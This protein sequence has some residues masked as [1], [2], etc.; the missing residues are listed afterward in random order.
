MVV[1]HRP[2]D[3]NVG[4]GGCNFADTPSDMVEIPDPESKIAVIE[5]TDLI[6]APGT[7]K[8]AKHHFSFSLTATP[9]ARSL[10]TSS[11]CRARHAGTGAPASGGCHLWEGTDEDTGGTTV[12]QMFRPFCCPSVEKTARVGVRECAPCC[13]HFPLAWDAGPAPCL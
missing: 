7:D 13:A 1:G 10:V 9:S 12:T 5:R 3:L 11:V 8:T 2:H 6:A 4:N